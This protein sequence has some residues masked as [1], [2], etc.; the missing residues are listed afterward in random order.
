MYDEFLFCFLFVIHP[1]L[2]SEEMSSW[3]WSF[4]MR[5]VE[6]KILSECLDTGG[7]MEAGFSPS[8]SSSS[9]SS[10][11]HEALVRLYNLPQSNVFYIFDDFSQL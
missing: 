11:V 10:L 5:G 4:C 6:I 2:L 7:W 8:P 1:Q 3:W 9:S